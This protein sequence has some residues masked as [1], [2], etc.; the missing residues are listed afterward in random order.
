[1]RAGLLLS[2]AWADYR[3]EARLSLCAIFALAA[4]ITPLLV[5]FGLKYGL[6]STLTERLERAPSVREIIP[7]GG[8]R[9]RAEDIAALAARADVAFAVPRTRQIAATADLSGGGETALSV[10]MIPSAAGDPLLAGLPQ[11]DRPTRVVLSHGAAEKLGA[12]P[13]ER[14][15]AR[16]GRR[17]DGQAQSQRLELEVLA[18]LPQERFAR[19]ALFA[20]LALLEAAEDYRDGRA[21][22]AYGWPGK[23]GEAPRARIYP[24]FRL[25]AR[26]LDA[27]EGLRRH[28]V[29]SGVEV[30]TQAE[31]IAQVRSLSRNLGLVF[32]IVAALA[33][34]GAFAAIAASSLAAV[35]RKR[36]ALAVLRLL[37][38]PTAALVGF[39]MFLALFSAVFGLFLAGLLYAATAGALN[40]LFDNQSGEF[41]CR[42][43]P[44]HYLTALL[45]TL[46][47]SVLAAASGGWRAARIEAAEGLRDV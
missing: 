15:V 10:E 16:I 22:A 46:L 32:W 9:Y 47:C 7:V 21:V 44:S 5:L 11:P 24:G 14:I 27:V 1:M 3:G 2:L 26:D 40:H 41:V 30:A 43:L 18:V 25:Y 20:P 19:D 8:A 12:Q 31:A 4:V 37:G 39:V 28:F 38:F 17:M 34:G 23:A 13:G 35:E 29:A 42:L 45:A 6:V 36:R 33:I